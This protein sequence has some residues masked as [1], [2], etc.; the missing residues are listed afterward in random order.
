[1]GITVHLD[2][3]DAQRSN[4]DTH[5]DL[6]YRFLSTKE[7][8][9]R[10]IELSFREPYSTPSFPYFKADLWATGLGVVCLV[11]GAYFAVRVCQASGREGGGSSRAFSVLL[12]LLAALA[13]GIDS[14]PNYSAQQRDL[15]FIEERLSRDGSDLGVHGPLAALRNLEQWRGHIDAMGLWV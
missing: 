7:Q 3:Y 13:I 9:A 8:R 14:Y 5:V 12:A 10:Q 2:S 15:R 11:M 6:S 1:A 4:W